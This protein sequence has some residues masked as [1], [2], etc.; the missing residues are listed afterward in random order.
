MFVL[1]VILLSE[2]AISPFL[3][4]YNVRIINDGLLQ[5]HY[6]KSHAEYDV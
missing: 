1:I 3:N 4:N 5:S 2:F 6:S